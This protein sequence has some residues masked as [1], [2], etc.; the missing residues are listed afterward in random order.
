MEKYTFNVLAIWQSQSEQIS[1]QLLPGSNGL[2]KQ[3]SNIKVNH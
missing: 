1:M 2:S 3:R